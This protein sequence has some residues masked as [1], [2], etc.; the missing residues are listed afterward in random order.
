MT[1]IMI[2]IIITTTII[3]TM[4]TSTATRAETDHQYIVV[5]CFE[6]V[7]DQLRVLHCSFHND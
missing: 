7:C 5:K 2:T 6:L 4:D 1:T 3:I